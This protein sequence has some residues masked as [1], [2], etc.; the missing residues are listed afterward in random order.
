MRLTELLGLRVVTTSGRV[1]G[2]VHDALL[3][4]D[5][6]PRGSLQASFRLHA[7]AVGRRSFG[8]RLGFVSGH[9][10]T[11]RFLNRLLGQQLTLV[12]WD[13]IVERDAERLLVADAPYE[14]T[15][16]DGSV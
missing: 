15:D 16:A 11:P 1:L 6:P 5:G 3:V 14:L 8:T 10:A 13:A 7:V 4:Q 12:P 9:V 2:T